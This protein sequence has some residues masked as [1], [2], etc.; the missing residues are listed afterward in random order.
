MLT[1]KTIIKASTIP[2]SKLV[3]FFPSSSFYA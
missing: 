3:F 2:H 1:F